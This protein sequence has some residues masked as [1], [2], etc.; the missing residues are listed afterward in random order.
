VAGQSI[1]FDFLSRGAA[2]V[3]GDFRKTGDNAALAARGAK[4]LGEAIEKLGAKE[5]RTAEE[6]KVL[7]AALRE[8]GKAEDR[9]TARAVLADAAVRRL[10]DAMKAAAKKRE[11]ELKVKVDDSA[12]QKLKKA[13]GGLHGP[14]L[15]GPA[16]LLAPAAGVLGGV[17]AGAAAGL[18]GAFIAA[19][20]ALAAFGAVA[21]PVLSDALKAEQ[22]IETAAGAHAAAVAKVTGQ[23]QYAMS[24]AKTQAQR[25]AAYAAEQKGFS[26]AQIAQTT[27][28]TK[29]YAGMSDAQIKL[30]QQLG[31]M[32]DA[33]NKVKTA[34][35]PVIAGSLQPWL[36]SVT[37]LTKNLAPI[38]AKIAPV[39]ASLG[40]QFDRL[41]NSSAFRGFRDFIGST[42]AAAVSAG[43]STI[44]D[45][46]KSFMILLPKFDPLIR[47]AVG[48]ISRLGP[49]VLTWASSKKA[50]DDITKF[51]QWFSKNGPQVGDLLK[52]IGGALKALAPGLASGGALEL[53]VISDFLGLIAKLPPALAKPLAEVAGAALILSKLGVLKVGLQI[54]GPAV[55]WLTGGLI[56]LGGGAA[57]G[58]EIRAAM[59]SGGAAAAAEI[60]AA[61][62][63]G[64][65]AAGA[66][67]AAG[68][69]GAGAA[70][71]TA[72]GGG[73]VAAFRAALSPALAGVVAGALIRA[74]GDTLSPAGSFAGNL[75]KQFQA[76]GQLWS[77][78][79]LH[80]FTFGGLEAWMTTHFG[81]PVGGFL[82]KTTGFLSGSWGKFTGFLSGSWNQTW[83]Q[84]TGRSA[85]G[86]K[87]VGDS[88]AAA[89]RSADN[90]RTRNL[91]PLQGEFGKVTGGIQG[92]SGIIQTTML[93]ALRQAGAKSDTLRT[94]NLLPLRG[95]VGRVSGGI[96]GLQG[97]INALH[98]KTVNVGVHGSGSGGVQITPS[99]GVPGAKNYA[100]Y[101]KPAAQGWFVTGGIP[102]RDSVPSMLKPGEL[103]VPTEMVNAGA[104]DHLRGKLPGFATG[105]LIG[106]GSLAG[107]QDAVARFGGADA[108]AEARVDV[109]ALVK[110]IKD[111][112]A[113][114]AAQLNPF[115]GISGVPSGGPIGAGAAAAQRF[116]K[117]ILWA[118]G[119]GPGQFP[120]LQALWNG[121]SGWRWNALNPSS[122]A[123]GIPQS[124][125][126]SKMA[127]AGADWRT[128]PATQIRWGLGY[129][130]AAYG[131]PANAYG[132]WLGRSPH[133]YS[134]GG[135]VPGYASGGTVG[136]QGAAY[137]KAWQT[138]HGGGFGAAW[139]PV[140]VNAQID[141]ANRVLG[142]DTTL[143]GASLPA[144]QHRHYVAAAA[145]WRRHRDALVHERG[146]MRDWRGQLGGSDAAI[147]SWI[148]AAGTSKALAP[149]VRRWK[150][151]RAFQEKEI[152]AV[153]A[154]LGWSAAQQAAITKAHPPGVPAGPP[155]PAI[156]HTTGA[157]LDVIEA[158][159]QA[160]AAPF[161]AAR[162]GLIMDSGG[163]LKPGWNPPSFNGTGRPEH[164]V[165]ARGGGGDIHLHLTVNAPVGSQR[166]LEDW[167]VMTANKTAHHGRLTQAVRAA[168]R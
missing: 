77:T 6:S 51:M 128:N 127:S 161:G 79:L 121:E 134:E 71:G 25:D 52:N 66:G 166:Q 72:A 167:F 110:A 111:S 10:D 100:V 96:Q 24:I 85:Q 76:D 115:A 50:A 129:I 160:N 133:W 13:L 8:T 63:G 89:G 139:G 165:P 84:I 148:A 163:W 113:A 141:A 136:Q 29:A 138:R 118:Y 146:V 44:I 150:S 73:F 54:I 12:L 83:S 116:A 122:G 5:G 147:T 145:W 62:A 78:S 37:D 103:V 41:V 88:L 75:N 135:L 38:I 164:L 117:S 70:G 1:T 120:P 40:T 82:N 65:A 152:A 14:G 154:M 42:G 80:S 158:F 64:G 93:N 97:S 131:S 9:V 53:K 4:I 2:T 57:A 143:A 74:A 49:A 101:F 159:L 95:E 91:V 98:G 11:A 90:L 125:P 21:K 34:E 162:G 36:K 16:L 149:S 137:L 81:Q 132:R 86:S 106:G 140:T 59:V 142:R 26:N 39:I 3:A 33:W 56:N 22:K 153:S 17:A 123:Y 69:A 112:I 109:N 92:L 46:V 45:L 27:A 119:W 94:Q 99:S 61:M 168:T 107:A 48:W 157:V 67:G 43:G 32:S 30:S 114:R 60:R 104:V 126:A 151:Q 31:A 18:G 68:S 155:L 102:G 35:T 47:E 124:L 130:K 20:G 156:T 7:A 144:S 55:K 108:A 23:Y 15:L 19:G 105:G 28:Q 87:S 58:T